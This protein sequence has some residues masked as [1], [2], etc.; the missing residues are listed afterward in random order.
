MTYFN[1]ITNTIYEWDMLPPVLNSYKAVFSKY[2]LHHWTHLVLNNELKLLPF[3]FLQ[4]LRDLG[5]I[6]QLHTV[7]K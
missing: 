5:D 4:K 7:M 3:F 2:C 1:E 6:F